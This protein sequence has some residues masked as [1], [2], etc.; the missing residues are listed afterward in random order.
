LGKAALGLS[1]EVLNGLS[2]PEAFQHPRYFNTRI[3]KGGTSS[4]YESREMLGRRDK[5]RYND[6]D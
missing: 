3:F 6:L 5:L 4:T 2:C 1:E